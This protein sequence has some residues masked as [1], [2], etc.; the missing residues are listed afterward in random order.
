MSNIVVASRL[1][2]QGKELIDQTLSPEDILNTQATR[3]TRNLTRLGG[4]G[5]DAFT[6]RSNPNERGSLK[7]VMCGDRWDELAV[8]SFSLT[9]YII[10]NHQSESRA[11]RSNSSSKS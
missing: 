7:D 8:K 2:R 1:R 4:T 11:R 5:M 10:A 6:T 9:I 3:S